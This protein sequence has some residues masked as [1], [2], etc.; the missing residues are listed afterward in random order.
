MKKRFTLRTFY[1]GKRFRSSHKLAGSLPRISNRRSRDAKVF[2]F[3]WRMARVPGKKCLT[4]ISTS[5]QLCG[6]TRYELVGPMRSL[7]DAVL[8]AV[9]EALGADVFAE[10]FTAGQQLSLASPHF[11]CPKRGKQFAVSSLLV[12]S[13]CLLPQHI[14]LDFAARC[15]R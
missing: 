10:L 12:R 11:R 6:R 5:F 1:P 7:V 9:Q 13:R 14:A 3:H 2:R 8:T 4:R 15:L